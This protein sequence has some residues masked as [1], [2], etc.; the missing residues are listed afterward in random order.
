M[1]ITHPECEFTLVE[2]CQKKAKAIQEIVTALRLRNV[3]VVNSRVEDV[4]SKYDFIV[5]RAVAPLPV[6]LEQIYRLCKKKSPCDHR[7]HLRPGLLYI[8]GGEFEEEIDQAE[9]RKY[10]L[11]DMNELCNEALGSAGKKVLKN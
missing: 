11:Y 4:T 7:K 5:G 8:K 1:A 10:K 6:L 2:S 9:V 3:L